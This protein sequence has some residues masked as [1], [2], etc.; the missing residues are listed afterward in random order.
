MARMT[1]MMIDQLIRKARN[2]NFS[3]ADTYDKEKGF[4]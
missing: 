3:Q 4:Q 1:E 2:R